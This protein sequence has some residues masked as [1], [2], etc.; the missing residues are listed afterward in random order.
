MRH[1]I[2]IVLAGDAGVGKSTLITS[3]VKDCFVDKVQEVVP[4]ITLP[5]DV[6]PEGVLTK[7]VDTSGSGEHREHQEN[8]LRRANVILLVYSVVDS[9][10]LERI[11]SYWLPYVRS[12][13]INVP[14]VLVGSKV[15][16]R[17]DGASDALEEEIAPLM[18]EFKE[19][20]TCI[21]CSSRWM[22]NIGEV[23]FFAQK[24][25]LY[26]TA[27]LYDSHSHTLKSACVD[28]LCN[29]F[30]LCD[31]DKDDVLSDSELIEFQHLCFNSPLQ[32]QELEGI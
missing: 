19:V 26:P 3:L 25:V 7:I 27:P 28:A 12:L 15:D 6:S 14:V 18:T 31:T 20:E 9:E 22:L 5:P 32:L 16:L 11:P 21:E 1:E 2:R 30:R 10:S 13:G 4:G 17:S 23:F 24:A 29:I 8:E